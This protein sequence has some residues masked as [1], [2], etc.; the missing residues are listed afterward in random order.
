MSHAL[1]PLDTSNVTERESQLEISRALAAAG[2]GIV[3]RP[4][5][6]EPHPLTPL[7]SGAV[8][9]LLALQR[10]VAMRT[11]FTLMDIQSIRRFRKLVRARMI[12]YALAR[13]VTGYSMP[14][15]GKSCGG[16]DHSTVL[17]GLARVEANPAA[18][19]PELSEL[20][21]AF[22]KREDGV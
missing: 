13:R 4:A 11:G 10:A 7:P 8:P 1:K 22:E 21:A 9:K 18:F 14:Q 16:R 20:L 19:E 2:C 12:F 15:I 5:P 6:Q 3:R 17:N